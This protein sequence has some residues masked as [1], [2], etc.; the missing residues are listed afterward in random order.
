MRQVVIRLLRIQN[1]EQQKVNAQQVHQ[2]AGPFVAS[3]LPARNCA[4]YTREVDHEHNRLQPDRSVVALRMRTESEGHEV[5]ARDLAVDADQRRRQTAQAVVHFG[6]RA[7]LRREA[8]GVLHDVPSPARGTNQVRGR[9]ESECSRAQPPP[10]VVKHQ[11]RDAGKRQVAADGVRESG[12]ADQRVAR[13]HRRPEPPLPQCQVRR[14]PGKAERRAHH[15]HAPGTCAQQ[16]VVIHRHHS[17]REER[18]SLVARDGLHHHVARRE[19][20]KAERHREQAHRSQAE[21]EHLVPRGLREHVQR[22]HPVR[23]LVDAFHVIPIVQNRSAH[24]AVGDEVQCGAG[25]V[26]LVG[27]RPLRHRGGHGYAH[28][29]SHNE[30]N[31]NDAVAYQVQAHCVSSR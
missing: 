25:E 10:V 14:Q 31:K 24:G 19:Q 26:A 29:G 5:S 7:E 13:Q 1:R 18:N 3:N 17:G 22:R 20:Q 8:R 6:I 2:R 30:S 4:H 27:A 16:D 11:E 12:R 28:V 23:V 9:R 15:I 21:T